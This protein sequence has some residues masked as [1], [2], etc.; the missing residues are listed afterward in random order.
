MATQSFLKEFRVNKKNAHRLISALNNEKKTSI[1]MDVA[2]ETPSQE[3]IKKIF[4][5]KEKD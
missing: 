5:K 3:Q 2:V 4:C 1:K